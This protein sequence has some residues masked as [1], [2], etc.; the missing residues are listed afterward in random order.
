M[1]I[2]FIQ[3]PTEFKGK[4]KNFYENRLENCRPTKKNNKN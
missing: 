2:D 1:Y 3:N 4:S